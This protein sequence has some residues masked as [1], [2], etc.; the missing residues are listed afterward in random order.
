MEKL[1]IERTNPVQGEPVNVY[2]HGSRGHCG[3]VILTYEEWIHFNKLIREGM[4]SLKRKNETRIEIMIKGSE[5]QRPKTNIEV[6]SGKKRELKKVSD[7]EVAAIL[8][9]IV[10][11]DVDLEEIEKAEKAQSLVRSLIVEEKNES[12]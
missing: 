2:F 7:E 3:Q 8:N 12:D 1:T 10:D 4:D 6:T 9:P 5:G 11:I